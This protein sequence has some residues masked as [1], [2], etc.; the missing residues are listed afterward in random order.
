MTPGI[1]IDALLDGME[2]HDL[3]V[4]YAH[5]NEAG[6]MQVSIPCR[7]LPAFL[8]DPVTWL[9]DHYHVSRAQYLAWHVMRI[10]AQ[11]AQHIECYSTG[12]LEF[13]HAAA[14][15]RPGPHSAALFSHA[16]PE[17]Q[18]FEPCGRFS[19]MEPK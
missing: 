13:E 5:R 3:T 2:D 4:L 12:F 10:A 15:R 9:A 18:A 14:G 16:P 1:T 17:K 6:T 8:A 19:S 11:Y 7:Q